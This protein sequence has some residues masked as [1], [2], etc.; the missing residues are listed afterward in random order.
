MDENNVIKLVKT[1]VIIIESNGEKIIT[2]RTI[3]T[4]VRILYM[5]HPMLQQIISSAT[6]YTT[7]FT[8]ADM[9]GGPKLKLNSFNHYNTIVRN[10]LGS[11]IYNTIYKVALTAI[12]YLCG[13]GD[14]LNNQVQHF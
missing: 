3:Q 9:N 13:A 1:C 12:P 7:A 14:Y 10:H 4:A 11:G 2:A 8:T 5:E 6:R